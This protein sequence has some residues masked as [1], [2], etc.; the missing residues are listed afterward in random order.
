MASISKEDVISLLMTPMLNFL[1]FIVVVIPV[2]DGLG[3]G[4]GG[5][6]YRIDGGQTRPYC[7]STDRVMR[8]DGLVSFFSS[9][10]EYVLQMLAAFF[11]V[12]TLAA[13]CGDGS[14]HFLLSL[15]QT[16]DRSCVDINYFY[17][18]LRILASLQ[19]SYH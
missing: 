11:I 19:F 10:C 3:I 15:L 16:V 2:S 7:V 13:F 14:Q 9:S 4:Q 1:W 12:V 17:N 18:D 6:R 8:D 5:G